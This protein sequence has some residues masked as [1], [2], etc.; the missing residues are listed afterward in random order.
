[1][2]T[3]QTPRVDSGCEPLPCT[4][5][6]LV[7]R[8]NQ[9]TVPDFVLLFLPPCGPHLIPSGHRVHRVEPTCLSTHRWPQRLRPFAPLFTCTNAN[10]AA[11][12]TCN[13][14]P[15]VS[16]HHV[17]N[18]SS[19]Q[20]ATIHRSSDAPVLNLPLDECIDNSHSHPFIKER[21]RKEM[22]KEL[23]QVIKSQRKAKIRSLERAN[24]GPLR[25][26]Q[27]LNTTKT[28]RSKCRLLKVRQKGST[29][30]QKSKAQSNARQHKELRLHECKL[31]LNKCVQTQVLPL[32]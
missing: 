9:E 20:G 18:H 19:H 16:P 23:K 6:T 2:E 14:R 3:N 21:K 11:T 13:T 26:G 5:S 29:H 30:R 7:L 24:L 27:R 10:Q 1:V 31:L 12:C 8:L 22:N 28:K 17:V 32:N 15:R 4:G 25:Q